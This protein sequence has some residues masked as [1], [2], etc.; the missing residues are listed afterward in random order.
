M[1]SQIRVAPA[2]HLL[3]H[4]RTQH[5]LAAHACPPRFRRRHPLD[6]VFGH[7]LRGRRQ[8]VEDLRDARQLPGMRMVDERR[9]KA[10]L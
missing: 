4:G 8:L 9:D 6:Q 5:L 3:E 10:E 1:E 7:Q 2:M